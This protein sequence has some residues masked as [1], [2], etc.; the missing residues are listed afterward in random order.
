MALELAEQK[1]YKNAIAAIKAVWV[2]MVSAAESFDNFVKGIAFVT[3]LSEA[4]I[5]AS[6][7]AVHWREF[8]AKASQYLPKIIEKIER[9]Y[10]TKKW[11]RKYR[12]A[13][14]KKA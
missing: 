13:W 1:W 11:S 6:L 14:T 12:A 2:Q 3:G 8:Q 10:R 4:E 9:A 7:P 5:R